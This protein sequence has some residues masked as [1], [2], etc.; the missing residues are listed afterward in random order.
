LNNSFIQ[1]RT[2]FADRLAAIGQRVTRDALQ[3][4]ASAEIMLTGHD[5]KRA[6]APEFAQVQVAIARHQAEFARMQSEFAR[7]EAQRAAV[8]ACKRALAMPPAPATVPL[9]LTTP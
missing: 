7:M 9:P 2:S 8:M 1:N 3:Q 5:V 6:P 4:L